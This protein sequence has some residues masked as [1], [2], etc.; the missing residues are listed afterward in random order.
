MY[1]PLSGRQVRNN[2]LPILSKLVQQVRS[3]LWPPIDGLP[4]QRFVGGR[5][6]SR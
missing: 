3:I 6:S 2:T 5:T 4:I 1:A